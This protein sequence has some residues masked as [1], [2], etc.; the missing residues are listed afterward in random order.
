MVYQKKSWMSALCECPFLW[1]KLCFE[2]KLGLD[3]TSK[4]WGDSSS[5]LIDYKSKWPTLVQH[6]VLFLGMVWIVTLPHLTLI[7]FFHGCMC[8]SLEQYSTTGR[9]PCGLLSTFY[10]FIYHHQILWKSTSLPATDLACKAYLLISLM[11]FLQMLP[12]KNSCAVTLLSTLRVSSSTFLPT[13][14]AFNL[15]ICIQL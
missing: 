3:L 8:M 1:F 4:V 12:L 11:R 2:F 15:N 6:F 9:S 10:I 14:L 7:G 5:I 13:S